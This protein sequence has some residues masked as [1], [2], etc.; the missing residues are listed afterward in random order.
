MYVAP[1]FFIAGVGTSA[2]VT[3]HHTGVGSSGITCKC[4][5]THILAAAYARKKERKQPI[6]EEGRKLE[7]AENSNQEKQRVS[8]D[9]D[10]QIVE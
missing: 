4:K 1:S 2:C 8:V 10:I 3:S 6:N 5:S 7:E 9:G